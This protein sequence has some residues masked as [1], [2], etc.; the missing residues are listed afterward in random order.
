MMVSQR[1]LQAVQPKIKALQ[2]KHKKDHQKL[3]LEMMELYKKE[4]V[5]PFG[6]CGF[7]LLQMPVLFVIYHVILQIQ[8]PSNAYH[9]YSFLT[10]Y[11]LGNIS[12]DF[13]GMDLLASG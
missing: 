11:N 12:Y 13:F 8:D 9:L 7:L 5:S 4:N 1:K 10:N 3:G 2:E 6:S